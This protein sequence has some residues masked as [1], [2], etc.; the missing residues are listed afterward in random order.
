[1]N[2][3][4][5]SIIVFLLI[6]SCTNKKVQNKNNNQPVKLSKKEFFEKKMKEKKGYK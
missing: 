5:R 1:M 4:I 2:Y 3:I 6:A